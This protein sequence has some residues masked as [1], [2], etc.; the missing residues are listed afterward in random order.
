MENAIHTCTTSSC[1]P[2]T[3]LTNGHSIAVAKTNLPPVNNKP[4]IA[5]YQIGNDKTC[6]S[7]HSTPSNNVSVTLTITPYLI[8]HFSSDEIPIILKYL[9]GNL[10]LKDSYLKIISAHASKL[11]NTTSSGQFFDHL[12][13]LI[14]LVEAVNPSRIT[15][16]EL[17][18]TIPT[19][20]IQEI[21]KNLFK[22]KSIENV[23]IISMGTENISDNS[24]NI[25]GLSRHNKL[26]NN[27]YNKLA[28]YVQVIIVTPKLY[29]LIDKLSESKND[30]FGYS[31][32][33]LGM[34]F[35]DSFSENRSVPLEKWFIQR[36]IAHELGHF[37][38]SHIK[39]DIL[40]KSKHEE[41]FAVKHSLAYAKQLLNNKSG[42]SECD[43][44]LIQKV[45]ELENNQIIQLSR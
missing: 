8:D 33:L 3:Q 28:K 10:S 14:F 39:Q 38:F 17:K 19:T 7:C 26:H 41:L 21:Q 32:P 15:L 27:A 35:I 16:K 20:L 37:E 42:L 30:A 45:I 36:T 18:N 5:P 40:Y 2:I 31:F 9:R 25:L 13:R 6:I 22:I 43:I 4:I 23:P 34:L 29:R 1:H 11:A 12:S 24:S 44:P